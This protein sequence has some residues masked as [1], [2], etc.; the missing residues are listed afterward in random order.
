MVQL[1]H[2]P[3]NDEGLL[4]GSNGGRNSSLSLVVGEGVADGALGDVEQVCKAA[5]AVGVR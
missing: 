1:H 2:T 4:R 5:L 3:G